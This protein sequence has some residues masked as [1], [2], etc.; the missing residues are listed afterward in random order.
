MPDILTL[1]NSGAAHVRLGRYKIPPGGSVTIADM[2][3][4]S[5]AELIERHKCGLRYVGDAPADYRGL[6]FD[7]RSAG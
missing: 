4:L 7:I 6:W 3:A 5:I 1:G 2:D